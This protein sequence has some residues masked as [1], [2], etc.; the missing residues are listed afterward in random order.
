[1]KKTNLSKFTIGLSVF[2]LS[3]FYLINNSNACTNFIVTNGASTDSSIM[4]TYAAD[5]HLLYGELY[6]WKAAV[7]AP[8]TMLDVYEWDTGKYLG[9]IA[10]VL[11]TYN[12]V[13]NVNE[14]QVAIGET[15]YGGR[16]EL[17]DTTGIIDYG[18]LMY[19]ALQRAKTAREA[20]QVMTELV[21][22][23]GYY[24][25]GE[26]FSIADKNEAWILEIIGKGGK[27]KG[28]VWV[29]LKI[30]DGYV[31]AHAN[32]ARITTFE[33]QEVNN[34]NDPE[35]TTFN[36]PDVITFAREMEYFYGEDEE[37]SFSD[38]YAPLTFGGA[39]FCEIRVWAFFNAIT[40]GMEEYWEYAKGNVKFGKHGYATN[41]MPLWVKPTE[42]LS[43]RNVMDLMG[44]H[45][46]GTELDMSKDIGA[47]PYNLPY[48][49]RPLTWKLDDKRYINERATATQQTGFSFV[50]QLRPWLPDPIG[51]INW[52]GV[53]DA[54]TTV[55][56]PL[57]GGITEVPY[58]F[59][60]GNGD[61]MEFTME[62][63]F[64]IFNLVANWAYT[65]YRDMYPDIV[66]VQDELYKEFFNDLAKLDKEF[67]EIYETDKE[68]AIAMIT[69]YSVKAGEKT[70][71]RWTELF[72]Y[73]FTKYM[74]G[75]IKT[76]SEVPDGY[77]FFVPN[78]EWPGYGEE[79]YRR[80]VEETEDQFLYKPTIHE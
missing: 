52:F 50:G 67:T 45:L 74:D 75:Y 69:E 64:W 7:H 4:I 5:S 49:W 9:K 44:D 33:Y 73:L 12:V 34:W 25:G 35:Q 18:S 78:Y 8:G 43:L 23:Y 48:R 72:A 20:M 14:H 65:R 39:R 66:K 77:K 42:K 6:Y 2:C 58:A 3:V 56:V 40:D 79:W 11:R 71:Q 32:Q 10:Q 19:I 21:E 13:G 38:T 70:H 68:K 59:E 80:I 1:M 54:A 46:E 27:S 26:S 29:A 16:P 15:T 30:P 61:L 47:G 76:P 24:S 37:F 17:V 41:R 22:E 51:G 31:S 55:Y 63:A 57:F 60:E 28:V 62:S 36:S 53:D